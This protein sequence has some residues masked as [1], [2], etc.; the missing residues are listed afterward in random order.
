ME[1]MKISGRCGVLCLML[2]AFFALVLAPGLSAGA[3]RPAG[4]VKKAAFAGSFYPADRNELDAL[5]EKYLKN[6]DSEEGC[7]GYPGTF[8]VI[9][10]HAGYIYSGQV[11]AC[12]YTALRGTRAKTVILLGSSHRSFFDGVAV[13]PEG[14]WE[15]PFGPVA[16]DS[17]M[18]KSLASSGSIIKSMPAAFDK[19]HSLE[20]QL[21]FLQKIF[22]DFTIV[23]LLTGRIQKDGIAQLSGI[24]QDVI[25]KSKGRTVLVISSDMSHYL[26]YAA[27]RAQDISTLKKIQSLSW[28]ALYDSMVSG[29]NEVCGAPAVIAAVK[30]TRDIGGEARVLTY[31]NSGDTAGDRS[32]VVGYGSV[33]F[34]RPDNKELPPLNDAEKKKLLSIARKTLDEYVTTKKVPHIDM[35]D[36]RLAERSGVFVT[37]N[38]QGQLRG[39]IGYIKAAEPLYR[40]VIEMTVSAASRDMRFRPVRS[41]E[42]KD[43]SIEISV[44]SPLKLIK[45]PGEI[46]VGRHGL[47]IVKDGNSGLLLPQVAT[48]YKWTREEFLRNTCSKAGLPEN[49]WKDKGTRIYIFSAQVFSEQ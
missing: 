47:Y 2:F 29:G 13:Y 17:A 21:P 48:H 18:A 4:P 30:M 43:I 25:A 42:V 16:I 49:A 26:A 34:S 36:G 22:Q 23:P 6:A 19:E 9:S 10:P 27:A 15:T 20:V 12:S 41:D 44:L 32:R 39:C 31:A 35:K 8:A 24:L 14:S 5:I 7:S 1:P 37:L 46:E 28:E 3:A 11:A 33:L 40:S 38:K 45:A